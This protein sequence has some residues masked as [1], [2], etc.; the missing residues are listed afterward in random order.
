MFNNLKRSYNKNTHLLSRDNITSYF[1]YLF[2]IEFQYL[3]NYD[4][5]K[6]DNIAR[7]RVLAYLFIKY[8]TCKEDILFALEESLIP[9]ELVIS[10]FIYDSS[11]NELYDRRG[12]LVSQL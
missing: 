10:S 12:F 3:K 1:W 5:T 11:T 7:G 9:S 2:S 4:Y 8:A 6:R